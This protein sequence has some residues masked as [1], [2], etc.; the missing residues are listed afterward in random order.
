M[1]NSLA[2]RNLCARPCDIA[3]CTVSNYDIFCRTG[4]LA[5]R[6][7][8]S[9]KRNKI[10]IIMSRSDGTRRGKKHNVLWYWILVN[11]CLNKTHD[12]VTC[13]IFM[14][15]DFITIKSVSRSY[16]TRVYMHQLNWVDPILT[17]TTISVGDIFHMQLETTEDCLLR[18]SMTILVAQTSSFKYWITLRCVQ[19]EAERWSYNFPLLRHR[20]LPSWI[21]QGDKKFEIETATIEYN[22]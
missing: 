4:W 16:E 5:E 8:E 14:T 10:K 15:C 12:W 20:F 6:T 1:N 19:S 22:S 7:A 9:S 2:E 13:N 11:S 18:R 17:K 21:C 3:V